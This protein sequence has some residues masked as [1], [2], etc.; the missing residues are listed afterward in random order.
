MLT[1]LKLFETL[2]VVRSC[3]TPTSEAVVNLADPK[4]SALEK[5]CTT[6]RMEFPRHQNAFDE[7][8]RPKHLDHFHALYIRSMERVWPIASEADFIEEDR[9]V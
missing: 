9:Q 2:G 6:V 5:K 8:N 7:R 1:V 4:V 3:R